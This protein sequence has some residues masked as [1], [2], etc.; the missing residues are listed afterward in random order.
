MLLDSEGVPVGGDGLTI[1]GT[2]PDQGF[3]SGTLLKGSIIQ[4]GFEDP[5]AAGP[6]GPA[7]DIFEFVFA[8]TD[9]DD[10]S[11]L[12]VGHK[13]YVNLFAKDSW[14]EGDFTDDFGN[15][16]NILAV[17]SSHADTFATPEPTSFMVWSFLGP[18]GLAYGLYVWSRRRRQAMQDK[19]AE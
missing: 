4:F 19:C 12:Y 6:I 15:S 14:F 13:A 8:A 10:L 17:V 9:G 18:A 3:S 5:P 16:G 1:T 2:V 11:P 7:A